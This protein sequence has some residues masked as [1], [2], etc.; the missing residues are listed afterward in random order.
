MSKGGLVLTRVICM[1]GVFSHRDIY[2]L[3]IM[4]LNEICVLCISFD[5]CCRRVILLLL[6]AMEQHKLDKTVCKLCFSFLCHRMQHVQNMQEGVH[7]IYDVC[8]C[9]LL[10]QSVSSCS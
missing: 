10:N 3:M 6:D 7:K 5:V 4:C 9:I 2:S 8:Q 1:V